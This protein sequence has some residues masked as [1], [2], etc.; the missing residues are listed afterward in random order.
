MGDIEDIIMS[1]IG[2]MNVDM[3]I[4]GRERYPINIRYSRELRDN[5]D[6]L[7]RV[8]VPTPTGQQIPLTQLAELQ[9]NTGPPMIKSEDGQLVGYVL[10]DIEDIDMGTYIR[11]AK[12]VLAEKLKMESG[13]YLKWSGQYEFMER[14]TQRLKIVIPLTLLIIFVLLYLNFRSF[15]KSL[16]IMFSL[17]FAVVG[18]IWFLAFLEY[19]LS[20]AVWVGM[21]AL[22]GVAAETGIVMIVYLDEAYEIHTIQTKAD[23]VQAVKDGAVQ[24]V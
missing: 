23:L 2:G 17:P 10:V 21:I 14:S 7:K 6:S 22:A 4:E 19:D 24:R 20:V 5:L 12:K 15:I 3:T 1:A 16:M 9:I 8:L 18:A 13:Y 11:N